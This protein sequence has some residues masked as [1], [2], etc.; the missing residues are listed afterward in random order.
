VKKSTIMLL[1]AILLSAMLQ[2]SAFASDTSWFKGV[3]ASVNKETKQAAVTGKIAS[4]ANQ[5]LTLKVIDPDGQ[6]FI[7][8]AK[9]MSEGQ[10]AFYWNVSAEGTYHVQI[11]VENSTV[12]Y[13]TSFTYSQATTDTP[14]PEP[15]TP[16]GFPQENIP[17]NS[18]H[19]P[20]PT[21]HESSPVV[22]KEEDLKHAE[23]GQ[24]KISLGTNDGGK[25][26]L[27]INAASIL[28]NNR[29]VV[30]NEQVSIVI[31]PA[32]LT[33]L[34][35]AYK[36]KLDAN[37]Q[38]VLNIYQMNVSDSTALTDIAKN[39]DASIKPV[40]QVMNFELGVTTSDGHLGKLNSF[41]KPVEMTLHYDAAD[42]NQAEIL[43]VYY[44]NEASKDWEYIGGKIDTDKKQIHALL[45]H[46]SKYALFAYD[47]SFS[48]VKPDHWAYNVI[49]SLTAKHIISGMTESTF[50]PSATTTRAQYA[51]MLVRAIGL[52]AK[53][54]SPF[55]D[56]TASDWYA[57]VV[58]AAYEAKLIRGRSDTV[59]APNE[60]I[61]REEMASM[62]VNA[63]ESID[64]KISSNLSEPDF[65]DAKDISPWASE[66]ILKV[67]ASGLMVGDG[68]H[69]FSPGR[70]T[71][72]AESVQSIYNLLHHS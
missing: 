12:P 39:K 31:D 54:T 56:V 42:Q 32:I 23:A 13:E 5:L 8:S 24:V 61:T 59:F 52:K 29:L 27:P 49:K 40:G 34:V 11:G 68:N 22:M 35:E 57:S 1:A 53:G 3:S 9:S 4:G 21:D 51:A 67:S 41:V 72:R 16:P 37:A 58:T 43:G 36:G 47:K 25:V 14:P 19:T 60:E 15:A 44:F 62:L 46:F 18:D 70:Y 63:Y 66:I 17:P 50:A 10:F 26:V 71:T 55:K 69:Q 48:D 2:V 20:A 6:Y 33:Q 38:F 65:A 28:G 7:D 45:P 64:G 30:Q